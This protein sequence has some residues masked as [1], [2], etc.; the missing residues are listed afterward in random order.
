[1]GDFYEVIKTIKGRPYRYKQRT[2]RKGAKVCTES[3][4]LGRASGADVARITREI[5]SREQMRR[6]AQPSLPMG[7][8]NTTSNDE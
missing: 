8:V 4:Y 1:M 6:E 5:A 2:F 3:H 7:G